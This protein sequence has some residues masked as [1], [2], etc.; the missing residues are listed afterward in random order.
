MRD[1]EGSVDQSSGSTAGSEV[2]C[3]M[4]PVVSGWLVGT[5]SVVRLVVVGTSVGSSVKNS[6]V[7][8]RDVRESVGGGGGCVG[9]RVSGCGVVGAE[10][11]G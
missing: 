7:V 4:R 6:V 5:D 9:V 2:G 3:V 10:V 8:P 1:V 11:S